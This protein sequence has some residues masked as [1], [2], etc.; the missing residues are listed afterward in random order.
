M[1]PKKDAAPKAGP[2]EPEK[3]VTPPG[4]FV[5]PMPSFI[6]LRFFH[7]LVLLRSRGFFRLVHTYRGSLL[8]INSPR[9]ERE[10]ERENLILNATS[11]L[12]WEDDRTNRGY[13]KVLLSNRSDLRYSMKPRMI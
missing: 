7:G 4:L 2:K 11:C 3:P 6:L 10:R 9:R 1:A 13:W 8:I 12:V 5:S